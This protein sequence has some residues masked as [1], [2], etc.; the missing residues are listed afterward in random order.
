MS[1]PTLFIDIT[2]G[3]LPLASA[4]ATMLL[5]KGAQ[6]ALYAVGRIKHQT[7]QERLDW[8][9]QQAEDIVE[10]TVL[11]ANQTMVN[12]LKTNDH[13]S[14]TEKSRVFQ[15]VLASV[16]SQ[17]SRQALTILETQLPDVPSYLSTLIESR[18][19]VAPNRMA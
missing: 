19:A 7:L 6:Y 18:V 15:T 9:V 8:A 3:I 2:K 5:A 12:T 13:W 11:A 1:V 17:M 14:S 4:F 10:N 16:T